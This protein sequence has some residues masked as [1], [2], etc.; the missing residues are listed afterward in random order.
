[1]I[2]A[3]ITTRLGFPVPYL[4]T[5][6]KICSCGCKCFSSAAGLCSPTGSGPFACACV[7]V[8]ASYWGEKN[9]A[10]SGTVHPH[11]PSE[12]VLDHSLE[13]PIH[14]VVQR[15]QDPWDVTRGKSEVAVSVR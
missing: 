6:S 14:T 5:S 13:H 4:I 12:A 9:S 15:V 2:L 1:M 8:P 7:R 11:L 3:L 10:G